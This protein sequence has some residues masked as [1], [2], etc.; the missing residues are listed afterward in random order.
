MTHPEGVSN[1]VPDLSQ[2]RELLDK[3]KLPWFLVSNMPMRKPRDE[4]APEPCLFDNEG[5]Y[6]CDSG[7]HGRSATNARLIL[8]A[9]QALPS[10]LDQITQARG[11]LLAIKELKATPIGDTGFAVGPKAL[12]DQ[13]QAIARSA[14]QEGKEHG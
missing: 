7:W 8:A 4:D 3:A 13:A 11:A 9:V 2:L 10:L 6:V 14:L 1:A 5:R 12:F